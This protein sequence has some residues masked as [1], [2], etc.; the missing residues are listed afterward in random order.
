MKIQEK[1]PLAEITTM[2]LGGEARFVIDVEKVEEIPEAMMFA[3]EKSLP[4]F[5]LGEGANSIGRDE[6]FPGV[7]VRNKITGIEI[8]DEEKRIIR[9]YGGENWDN[10]VN[11]TTFLGWSGIECLSKIPGSLGAAPVQNIGA[12]GQEISQVIVEVEAY[13]TIL[14]EFVTIPK[15]KM[16]MGYRKTIFNYGEKAGRYFIVSV[17]MRLNKEQLKAPFYNSLQRE[18]DEHEISDFSPENIRALVAQIR[19]RKL[20]DPKK[21]A[22]AGSFFKNVVI[23]PTEIAEAEAKG[24][25]VYKN[26]DGTGK[27]STGWLLEHAGLKGEEFFGFKV[28]EKAALILI[29]ESGRSYSDLEKA[30][31]HIKKVVREKFGYEIEQE[32]VEIVPNDLVGKNEMRDNC[33]GVEK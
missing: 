18:I 19:E 9:G 3:N 24:I 33:L 6:G 2:R 5:F 15:E 16:E 22:S 29:N 31:Y 21:V 32:P 30:V 25:P 26:P 17:T 8:I 12:Y 10:V 11:F 20:P 7:I 1:I 13:D 4:V 28:S 14:D 23:D 27:I